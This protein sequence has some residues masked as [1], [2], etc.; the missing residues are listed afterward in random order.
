MIT[1]SGTRAL[2]IGF[3]ATLLRSVAQECVVA[4]RYNSSDHWGKP[5]AFLLYD[6]QIRAYA[7]EGVNHAAGRTVTKTAIKM[8]LLF[9]DAGATDTTRGF[10]VL[11][12]D[13]QV[14]AVDGRGVLLPL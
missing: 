6:H 12:H 5:R 3:S 2:H 11:G 8:A 14:P 1:A 13:K 7:C 9:S 4:P 10:Q